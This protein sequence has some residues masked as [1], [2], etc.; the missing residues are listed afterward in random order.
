LPI[1]DLHKMFNALLIL[2]IVQAVQSAYTV[3]HCPNDFLIMDTGLVNSS[4]LQVTDATWYNSNSS[5]SDLSF[6]QLTGC[7]I[8]TELLS[9]HLLSSYDDFRSLDSST[10]FAPTEMPLSSTGGTNPLVS[11]SADDVCGSTILSSIAVDDTNCPNAQI[12]GISFRSLPKNEW[13]TLDVYNVY[14]SESSTRPLFINLI[15]S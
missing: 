11:K 6:L 10:A 8:Q 12:G 5:S 9:R 14:L 2:L 1:C 3:R 7:S 13:W 4:L 15:K